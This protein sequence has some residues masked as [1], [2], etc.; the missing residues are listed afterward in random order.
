MNI[1]FL[2]RLLPA[3]LAAGI[4]TK[5]ARKRFQY[6]ARPDELSW[7]ATGE[8]FE[9]GENMYAWKWG[10]GPLVILVHGWG[11]AAAQWYKIAPLLVQNGFAVVTPDIT[12]HGDS[13][14]TDIRFDYFYKDLKVLI[15]FLEADEIH[16][17][18]GHSAG[19][20][21]MMAGRALCS[22]R[23]RNYLCI[24][25]PSTPYPPIKIVK[26][27][28][29]PSEKALRYFKQHLAAQ[30]LHDWDE[31]PEMS[32]RREANSEFLLIYDENDRYLN[33]GDL[34]T[35]LKYWPDAQ[36]HK[37][38][39]IGHEGMIKDKDIAGKIVSFLKD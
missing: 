3:G 38:R 8:R 34:G 24:A 11:G 23:A 39:D 22:L 20:L 6:K 2:L 10:A 13:K 1:Q 21:A 17:F 15:D 26:R 25:T 31:I 33:P 9:Y 35:I 14:G 19:G 12:G 29:N 5:L 30:F 27:K 18:I 7:L 37:V 28:L 4:I 36:T 32:F 16:C